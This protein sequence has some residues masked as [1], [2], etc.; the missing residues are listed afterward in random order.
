MTDHK[1]EPPYLRA[2]RTTEAL[3][4]LHGDS[5]RGLAYPKPDGFLDRYRVYLDVLRF[6]PKVEGAVQLLDIGCGSGRLLDQIKQSG[7]TDLRYRGIDLS[8]IMIAAAAAKHPEARFILGDPL[9]CLALWEEPV[10]YVVFGGI[11]TLRSF[12]TEA[13]MADFMMRLLTLAFSHCRVGIAFNVMSKHVD[14]ERADL[15][16]VPFDRMADLI[17]R[18]LSR[19]YLFR[20]DYGLYEYTTYVYREPTRS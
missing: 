16:H 11:F 18:N 2:V 10:D 20:A 7:R 17:G 14:W 5:H 1:E 15:F 3:F 13:Q 4:R 12:D 19:H 8:E 9:D 6:G